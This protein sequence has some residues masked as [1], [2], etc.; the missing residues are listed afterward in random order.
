MS[1]FSLPTP[2]RERILAAAQRAGSMPLLSLTDYC[3]TLSEGGIHD[4]YS[5]GDYWWP[6]PQ[7]PGGLPYV[8]RDGWSNPDNFNHHRR[9]MR[10]LRDSVAVLAVAHQISGEERYVARAADFLTHFFLNSDT[11]MN[12]RLEFAQAI[13]GV[14]RG[15]GIGIIDSLHLIEVV[16]AIHA[17]ES[18][19]GFSSTV[20]LGLKKWFGDFLHWMLTSPEGREESREK[21][22]HAVAYWLQVAVFARY[23]GN[24]DVLSEVRRQLREVLIPEQM[25]LNGSFP[26]ELKRT[27]PYAYSIFQL[28]NLAALCQVLGTADDNLWDFELND[29][30]G[31][32]RAMAYLYPFLADKTRWP[33]P[34]DVE[35]WD[36]WPVRQ[37][38]LLF[39]GMAFNESR[40][41]E[42]WKQL[43]PES[44]NDEVRRNLAITQP[45]LWVGAYQA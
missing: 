38:C 44:A 27:K 20:N 19:P 39:S 11:R 2:E 24:A 36:G 15:R 9:V 31:M 22:N 21:N 5:N 43:T 18:S 25:A 26:S 1:T 34:P 35:Y 7:R 12:P 40:Y 28:D 41:L 42:L 29:G 17:L 4:F 14:C 33:L 37:P 6:D 3:A 13:P 30:R 32:R 10:E 8:R 45:G 16:A 23:S